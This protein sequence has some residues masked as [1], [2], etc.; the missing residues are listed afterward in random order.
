M[1]KVRKTKKK[2]SASGAHSS[3]ATHA[4]E[5]PDDLRSSQHEGDDS[6]AETS[7]GEGDVAT[8]ANNAE[9]DL[10]AESQ[11][12][13]PPPRPRLYAPA[14]SRPTSTREHHLQLAGR[15]YKIE[16]E[17]VINGQQEKLS[18]L[19]AHKRHTVETVLAATSDERS[20]VDVIR[21]N[22][23]S[24][25]RGGDVGHGNEAGSSQRVQVAFR[26]CH[27]PWLAND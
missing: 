5:E 20:P 13:A 6:D 23:S 25:V 2:S 8:P 17:R 15:M 24:P 16:M 1:F 18:E 26:C 27:G 3:S 14:A 19:A 4:T 7:V 21:M 12:Y 9:Q 22:R 11:V 10:D